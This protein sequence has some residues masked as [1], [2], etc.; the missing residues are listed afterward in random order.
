MTTIAMTEAAEPQ[1][2]Y[3]A[4]A[5]RYLETG[6]VYLAEARRDGTHFNACI[7]PGNST[8]TD[9]PG[10]Q[11]EVASN[12]GPGWSTHAETLAEAQGDFAAYLRATPDDI[13][14]PVD[15]NTTNTTKET[16]R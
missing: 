16:N 9:A 10:Y 3:I 15:E 2:I 4:G 8:T 7:T 12:T 11:L 6:P 5:D 13:D 1:W 14:E